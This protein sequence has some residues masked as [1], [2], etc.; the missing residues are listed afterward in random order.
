MNFRD[1]KRNCKIYEKTYLLTK[2]TQKQFFSPFKKLVLF[3]KSSVVLIKFFFLVLRHDI[4]LIF[5]IRFVF[6][7]FYFIFN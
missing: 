6:P 3:W 4:N 1:E 5:N 7:R 2:F